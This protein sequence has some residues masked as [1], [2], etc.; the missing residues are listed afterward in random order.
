MGA[1]ACQRAALNVV[2]FFFALG[3]V[4]V[5]PRPPEIDKVRLPLVNPAWEKRMLKSALTGGVLCLKPI[6]RRVGG[7]LPVVWDNPIKARTQ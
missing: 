1:R 4:T 6:T 2:P 5:T 7:V 3:R